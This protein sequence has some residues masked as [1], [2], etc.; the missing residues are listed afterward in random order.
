MPPI[1][2]QEWLNQNSVRKYPLSEEATGQDVTDSFEI[3]NNFIVDM[4]LPVHSTM[5]LD[6]SKF[7][8]LQLAI[9]GTGIS[10]TVGHNGAPV[11]TISVPVATFEPNKTY[12]LQGVGEFTDVLGK[13]VIGTLDAILRSAGSYAFDIAGGRIEPSVIVP[14][15]RGVAS[16]CIM[17]DDV[18]GELIQGDIAFEAGR[19]IRLI[20]SD[21]G[22][23]TILT[24]DAIDGEGTIADCICDGD[25]ADRPGIKTISGV[26]PDQQG[27]V[28]LEG[29]D[30][31]EIVPLTADYKIRVK[32]NC[33]KPC[34]GC[35]ELQ[36]LRDDQE[37]VRD[38]MLTMQN[39]AGRLEAVIS[40]MQSIVAASA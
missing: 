4:V 16:L 14:D 7:H 25:I 27:N 2:H 1:V 32:D 10:I 29:D 15:I 20:R 12:H 22:S 37:R 23:V 35:L 28:E 8:I 13:M 21:F 38:E 9:F 18:C 34:C 36:A 26:G 31:L 24:I 17:E 5:N 40:A 6:V 30:C 11:A 3:P 19:N 33:S 39:L